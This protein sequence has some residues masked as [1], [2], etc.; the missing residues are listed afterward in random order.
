MKHVKAH[1]T[2]K[3]KLGSSTLFE[4]FVMEGIESADLL[5]KEEHVLDG[6]LAMIK[7]ATV[8]Q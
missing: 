5:A 6:A 4:L 3:K 2:S 8:R 1:R 7:A